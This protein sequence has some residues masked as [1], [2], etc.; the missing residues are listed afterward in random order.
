MIKLNFILLVGVMTCPLLAFAKGDDFSEVKCPP[1]AVIAKSYLELETNGFRVGAACIDEKAY[2]FLNL[3]NPPRGS[4]DGVPKTSEVV[5]DAEPFTIDQ[6]NESN[7]PRYTV[8]FRYHLVS[9]KAA[10]AGTALKET[11]DRKDS[12]EFVTLEGP[13]KNRLGCALLQTAPSH[14][15]VRAKC[16]H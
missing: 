4:E 16:S 14:L 15:A 6:I 1:I 7:A 2:P 5:S 12:L 8:S 10:A 11:K 9:A 3:R 13:M